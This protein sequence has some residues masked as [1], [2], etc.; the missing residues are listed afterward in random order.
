MKKQI[1]STLFLTT[2]FLPVSSWALFTARASYGLLTSKQDI[3]QICQG[4]CTAPG[5]A[6]GILPTYGTGLDALV[7]LPLIPVGFGLRYEK[8]G[9]STS[10]SNIEASLNYTRTAIL[11]N[12]RLIDTI[13]HFGPIVSYG[14]SHTG[15]FQIKEG[16]TT[17]V[18]VS[19]DNMQSYSIGLELEVKPLIVV[20]IIVG[21]EV[22]YLSFNWGSTT[23]SIDNSK[24]DIDMSGT[25]MKVFLGL[26]I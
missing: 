14:I 10:A 25:Y 1:L 8:H 5:N 19:S 18:D 11:L 9:L 21:A 23:N 6:P 3:S 20:P 24:K 15:G 16:G 12:Y 22:G 17:K 4:S 2:I 26:D 13:I 7:K